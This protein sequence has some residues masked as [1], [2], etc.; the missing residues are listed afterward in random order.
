MDADVYIA[1]WVVSQ[2]EIKLNHGGT[3]TLRF[4]EISLCSSV[5]LVTPWLNGHL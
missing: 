1:A 2:F 3:K 5:N 4:T